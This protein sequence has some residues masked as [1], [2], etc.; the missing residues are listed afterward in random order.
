[1]TDQEK[2]LMPISFRVDKKTYEAIKANA[3]KE[4]RTI[5]NYMRTVI[6]KILGKKKSD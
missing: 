6:E 4:N 1:M 2:D 5:A 3:D